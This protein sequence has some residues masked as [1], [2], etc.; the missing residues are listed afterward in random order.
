MVIE[1]TWAASLTPLK[2]NLSPHMTLF[3]R[4]V[5]ARP[6]DDCYG[7]VVFGTTAEGTAFSAD[8]KIDT[9]AGL[10]SSGIDPRRVVVG[11]AALSA[12]DV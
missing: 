6:A 8:E 3:A 4:H 7:A 5:K 11:T 1:G 2:A 10:V 12:P 9:V